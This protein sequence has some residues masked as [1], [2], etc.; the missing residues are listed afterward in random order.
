M[1]RW[2]FTKGVH[3]IGSGCYAYLQP[4][5]G[6]G[7]SNAGLITFTDGA[8]LVDTLID[9]PLT[10]EMLSALRRATPAAQRIRTV[11]NTHAH[12][13]HT[14]GNSLLP[15]A[16]I[17]ASEATA[18]EM[19]A[20]QDGPMQRIIS[21]WQEFGEAGAFLHEVLGSRFALEDV[22]F[23]APTRTFSQELTLHAD[24]REI[25]LIKVGPAHTQGDTLTYLPADRIVFTGDI[26]FHK[27]HPLLGDGSCDAWIAACELILTWDVEVVVPGHG[28]IT[29]KTGVRELRDYFVYLR[30]ESRK[31]FDAG[32]SYIDAARDIAL[33]T[34]KDW[35]DDER[36][37]SNINALY[38]EF[39]AA[40]VPFFEELRVVRQHRLAKMAARHR[41]CTC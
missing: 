3:D 32:M 27:V 19:V 6:W 9:L 35:V 15:D 39:G 28:P 7:Y 33:D 34:Y 38:R 23:K 21:H 12:P 37:Y 14:G 5:G 31:R 10:R 8:L 4:D 16:E 29:D 17:I 25:R 41:D 2:Q 1:A 18:A 20:M 11:L 40:P 26:V 30:T 24:G 36:V 22:P 13:D